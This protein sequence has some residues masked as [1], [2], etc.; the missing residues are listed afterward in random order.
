MKKYLIVLILSSLVLGLNG[1]KPLERT[2]TKTE[3]VERLKYDSIYLQ[4]YD[5]IYVE[6]AGD[7]VRIEKYKTIYR[8]KFTIKRDSIFKTDTI[9]KLLPLKTEVIKETPVKGFFWWTGLLFWIALTAFAGFKLVTKTPI[10]SGIK[11]LL[12]IN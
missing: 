5:S 7:T 3:Y 6:K 12:K 10:I 11:K 8:D 2:T 4:K 9:T 1:C